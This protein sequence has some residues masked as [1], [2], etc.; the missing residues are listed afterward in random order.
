[1]FLK[2]TTSL[3]ASKLFSFVPDAAAKKARVFVPH[4]NFQASMEIAG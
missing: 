4:K 3:D 2:L 1:M